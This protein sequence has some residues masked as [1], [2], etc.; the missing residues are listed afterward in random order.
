MIPFRRQAWRGR[1]HYCTVGR[2]SDSLPSRGNAHTG[3]SV[4]VGADDGVR[5]RPL[6]WRRSNPPA[7]TG[8]R[9]PYCCWRGHPTTLLCAEGRSAS[10]FRTCSQVSACRNCWKTAL[11]EAP[12]ASPLCSRREECSFYTSPMMDAASGSVSSTCTD[13]AVSTSCAC[14]DGRLPTCL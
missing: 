2:F 7:G 14:V 10:C 5:S 3:N 11:T 8:R 13:T 12:T 4:D 1:R 6:E 9:Q